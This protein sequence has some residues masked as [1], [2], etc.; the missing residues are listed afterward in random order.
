MYRYWLNKK[1]SEVD[2]I[3]ILRMYKWKLRFTEIAWDVRVPPMV[4]AFHTVFSPCGWIAPPPP[5]EN[6]CLP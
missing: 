4:G 2:T 1:L 5:A 6:C 3:I